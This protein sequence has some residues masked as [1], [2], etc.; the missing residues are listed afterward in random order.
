MDKNNVSRTDGSTTDLAL[1]PA[2]NGNNTGLVVPEPI[3]GLGNIGMDDLIGPG[4]GLIA[5]TA[6]VYLA[7]KFGGRIHWAV[8]EYSGLFGGLFG[9]LCSIPLFYAKDS[10]SMISGAVSSA[11]LGVG[12]Q[13]IPGIVDQ[14]SGCDYAG[15]TIQPVGA[16]PEVSDA[17]QAPSA[18]YHQADLSAYGQVI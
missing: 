12:L 3:S 5:T 2:E 9:I 4:V 11:V 1:I 10:T 18:V 6:G 8:K 14:F 15:L 16:L 17:G 13:F 7:N